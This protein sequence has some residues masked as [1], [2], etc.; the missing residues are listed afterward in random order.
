MEHYPY[1]HAAIFANEVAVMNMADRLQ[2]ADLPQMRFVIL[3]PDSDNEK[4]LNMDGNTARHKAI[5]DAVYGSTGGAIGAAVASLAATSL[6]MAAFVGHPFA[7]AIAAIGYGTLL[8]GTGGAL[9][10]GIK[11]DAFLQALEEA[12]GQGHWAIVV[13]SEDRETDQEVS[14]LMEQTFTETIYENA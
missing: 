5:R 2:A 8:G 7:T 12:L 11:G 10:G 4:A 9:Y 1:K 13:H 6:K 3:K 14:R